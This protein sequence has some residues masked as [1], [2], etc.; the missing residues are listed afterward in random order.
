MCRLEITL[1]FTFIYYLL[2][3]VILERGLANFFFLVKGQTILG[4][5][6]PYSLSQLPNFVE[7]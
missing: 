7:A 5:V 6:G 1:Y 3:Q 4:F 2:G